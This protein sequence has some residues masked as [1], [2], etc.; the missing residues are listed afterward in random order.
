MKEFLKTNTVTHNLMSF[1]GFKSILIFTLLS[2]GPKT[3]A[4][5]QGAL[6]NH[7]YLKENVSVDTLRV[8][9]N[10]LKEIGCDI[11]KT[12]KKG[13]TTFSIASH[14]FELK[15]DDKQ[16][17]SIIKIYQ[18]IAKSIEV[19]DLMSLQ[20]FFEKM[21][22]YVTNEELKNDLKCIS[23]LN[24]ID[25]QL[26]KELIYYAQHNTEITVLY[27]S[28]SSDSN[29]EITIN[30]DKL[31][32]DNGKLYVYGINS[33]KMNYSSFLV[34]KID[35]ITNINF[36]TKTLELPDIIVKY[37]Y[38]KEPKEVLELLSCEKIL[39]EHENK[40]VIELVSKSK[41]EIMQRILYHSYKCKVLTP[42]T[43]RTEVISTL[44]KM[45][46]GYIVE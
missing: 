21:A 26:I 14:P 9:F 32:I 41:F 19:S 42:D 24:G 44:K 6:R 10:S 45:K 35:K 18:A 17:K 15:I 29:K 23:P 4:Q 43:I 16:A 34:S 33:E 3:Y 12:T 2:E 5:L 39:E 36:G 25:P 46:E 13:V 30:V 38:F 8:Y 20:N 28:A 27:K 37:E 7:E 22:E 31:A 40:Y 1:T 11:Q